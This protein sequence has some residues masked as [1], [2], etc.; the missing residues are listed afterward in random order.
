M[1]LTIILETLNIYTVLLQN[2]LMIML[3]SEIDR[4]LLVKEFKFTTLKGTV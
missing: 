2:Q 3:P 1:L 4:V